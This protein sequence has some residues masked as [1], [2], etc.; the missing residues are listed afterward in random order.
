MSRV[1]SAG[2]LR[3]AGGFELTSWYFFRVSG[4]LLLVLA[5]GHILITHYLNVPSFTTFDFVAAR[6]SN[7]L[8]RTFDWLLLTLAL[9]HG[10]NGARVA[11]DDWVRWPGWRVVL[12]SANASVTLIFLALGTVTIFMFSPAQRVG[13]MSGQL[14]PCYLMDG[15]LIA[16]S[17]ATYAGVLAVLV[18][19]VRLLAGVAR[20]GYVG[21]PGMFAW[22]LHRATGL[23]VL[24][25]LLI[26]IIDIMY[27][28]LGADVY[29]CTVRAYASPILIPMEIALVAAV[30]YHAFN[31]VRVLLIDFWRGGVRNERPLFYAALVLSALLT[32]PSAWVIIVHFLTQGAER[33]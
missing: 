26:H 27:V 8:W 28:N 2:R 4:V 5:L 19:I 17:L 13:P 3:P 7:P 6:W 21:D 16:L 24:G 31:G 15:F 10:A 30:L 20:L 12:H 9:L 32:L 23:G 18:A 33:P 14:W 22:V 1:A 11:V 25:F 29:D